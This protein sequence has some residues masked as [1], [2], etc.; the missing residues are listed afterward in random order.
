MGLG[1]VNPTG[2]KL[3]KPLSYSAAVSGKWARKISVTVGAAFA[4]L[5]CAIERGDELRLPLDSWI[6]GPHFVN[7]LLCLVARGYA[8]SC[9]PKYPRRRLGAQ[10]MLSVSNSGGVQRLFESSV[11]R[12]IH[13]VL[14]VNE[15]SSNVTAPPTKWGLTA[16]GKGRRQRLSPKLDGF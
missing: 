10:T 2:L 11:G 5:E 3:V 4:V 12:L 9:S 16:Q 1:F 14:I 7:A 6:E 13:A 8:E 15:M